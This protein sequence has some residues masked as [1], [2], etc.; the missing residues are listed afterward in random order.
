MNNSQLAKSWSSEN[1]IKYYTEHRDSV[2]ELY[3]S[4]KHFIER[5]VKNGRTVLDIGC[6]AGGFSEIIRK[7]NKNLDYT[8][9][10]ISKAM[11]D[12]AKKDSQKINFT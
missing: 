5:V 7:Y 6:A 9:V 11:I 3:E 4:E 2:K 8:G 10:D 1:A 12:Q